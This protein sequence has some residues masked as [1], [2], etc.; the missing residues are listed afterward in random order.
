[1]HKLGYDFNEFEILKNLG[2]LWML[3][4]TTVKPVR[5]PARPGI[6]SLLSEASPCKRLVCGKSPPPKAGDLDDTSRTNKNLNGY[7][8]LSSL[9]FISFYLY[10]LWH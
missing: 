2:S 9:F 7:E 3:S 6:T 5:M 10:F 8:K 4:S 1:V